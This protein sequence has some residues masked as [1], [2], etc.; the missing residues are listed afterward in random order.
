MEA[1]SDSKK[2]NMNEGFFKYVFNFD[3]DN[4]S[5]LLNLFQYSFL[6]TPLIILILKLINYYTP[7]DDDE[8]GTLEILAEIIGSLSV[9]L[10]SIWFIN[11]IIR[12]IP[13]YSKMDYAAFN[14]TNFLLAFLILLFTMQ[15]KLGA[16]INILVERLVDL[17]EGK[18]NLKDSAKKKKK[19][20]YKTTQ[21]I[22]QAPTHQPSQAD[23][24]NQQQ[25]QNAN[26]H[27]NT[28]LGNAVHQTGVQQQP[29]FNNMYG[30]QSTPLINAQEPMAANDALG[31][32][33]GGSSLF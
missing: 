1:L 31:G 21:P 3:D 17:Y 16:K 33:F 26:N 23:F 27:V 22:S 5:M 4:K 29:D 6:S 13:T 18:T 25:M 32:M 12:Y 30:G 14:E 9:I 2:D 8:K 7:E 20:D 24:L 10:L 15:T 28:Q 19:K 11:K